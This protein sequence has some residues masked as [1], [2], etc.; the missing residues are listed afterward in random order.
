M[1]HRDRQNCARPIQRPPSPGWRRDRAG[2]QWRLSCSPHLAPLPPSGPQP[3][4][5]SRPSFSPSPGTRQA[6]TR[7]TRTQLALRRTPAPSTSIILLRSTRCFSLPEAAASG[8]RTDEPSRSSRPR[9][10]VCGACPAAAPQVCRLCRK[11]GLS[12]SRRIARQRLAIRDSR[13]DQPCRQ[14]A[15]RRPC[16]RTPLLRVSCT[17]AAAVAAPPRACSGRA[18]LPVV[19]DKP[20]LCAPVVGPHPPSPG[21]LP[22]ESA[23]LTLR[24]CG[25]AAQPCLPVQQHNPC[26]ASESTAST[27]LRING[28]CHFSSLQ[29]TVSLLFQTPSL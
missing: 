27:L 1:S 22:S 14:A 7:T 2:R 4:C 11:A 5:I 3:R 9:G 18:C 28:H 13:F 26:R 25:A 29:F 15:P 20:R 6:S 21:P 10:H 19:P 23:A 12:E 16:R 8:V 24:R 17:D